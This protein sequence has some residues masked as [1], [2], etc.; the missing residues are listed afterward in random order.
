VP[1]PF[2]IIWDMSPERLEREGLYALMPGYL[3]AVLD[4]R[5][6]P[7]RRLIHK[8]WG[9]LC[10]VRHHAGELCEEGPAS[11]GRG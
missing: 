7:L 9:T 8:I 5:R 3:D 11:T 2:R 10:P 4:A 6:G 1:E